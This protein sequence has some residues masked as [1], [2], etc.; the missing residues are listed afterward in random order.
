MILLDFIKVFNH[1]AIGGK[2]FSNSQDALSKNENNPE[3]NLYSILNKLETFRSANGKFRLALCYPQ[4]VTKKR[5]NE[6]Y[7]TSNPAK[8]TTIKV[9]FSTYI[10]LA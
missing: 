8:E 9:H 5:C 7:Q 10:S 6:W 1:N 2:Y 4:I 3:A